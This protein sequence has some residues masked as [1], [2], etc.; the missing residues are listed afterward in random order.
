MTGLQRSKPDW[1][2]LPRAR[3]A[4]VGHRS[5]SSS[6]AFCSSCF[7]V[8]T[9]FSSGSRDFICSQESKGFIQ[10]T[11][12]NLSTVGQY[13]SYA[14]NVILYVL[15]VKGKRKYVQQLCHSPYSTIYALKDDQG[16]WPYHGLFLTV[17]SAER[18][19]QIV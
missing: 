18:T 17:G 4:E 2:R 19:D 8:F 13:F 3:L 7:L 15:L 9:G 12:L 5:R 14:K 6:A 1:Q 11:Y 10:S 16:E